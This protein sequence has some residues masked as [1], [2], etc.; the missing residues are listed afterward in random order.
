MNDQATTEKVNQTETASE[1]ERRLAEIA[2]ALSAKSVE[3]A[4]KEV[5]P[6]GFACPIDPAERA[7]CEGCQ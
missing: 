6:E 4:P 5:L 7:A 3:N 2:A 1:V